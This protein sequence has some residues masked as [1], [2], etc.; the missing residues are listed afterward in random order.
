M[1]LRWSRRRASVKISPTVALYDQI[2][3][4]YDATRSADQY[5]LSRLLHHLRPASGGRY[6]D[7]GCGTAN[8]T[9]A[10]HN[11]GVAIAGIDA[12][13]TMIM[14]ARAKEPSLTVLRADAEALPFRDASFTGAT[15]IW[16]HHHFSDPVAAFREIKRVLAPGGRLIVFSATA[17]QV[18]R[19]WLAEYFP[20]MMARAV[21]A[22]VGIDAAPLLTRAGFPV[23]C[24]EP[25]EIAPDLQ[26]R[27]LYAG[28]HRPEIYFDPRIRAG[29]S[30]FAKADDL[31]AIDRGLERL[32]SDMASGRIANVIRRYAHDGGDCMF[33]VAVK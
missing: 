5:L 4:D 30:A 21:G 12:S 28:K 16:A 32:K 19:Y 17:E 2:G 8:Y 13:R 14:R 10:M 31:D 20:A 26:D 27:F 24:E 25:Y 33:T 9:I 18:R 3:I 11:A 22:H 1:R 23:E 7:V 6:L 15:C 29:I